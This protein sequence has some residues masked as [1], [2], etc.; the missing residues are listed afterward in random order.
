MAGGL[1]AEGLGAT[2]LAVVAALEVDGKT[3]RDE[4]AGLVLPP[5][6]WLLLDDLGVD[7]ATVWLLGVEV[8]DVELETVEGTTGTT[9]EDKDTTLSGP[10]RERRRVGVTD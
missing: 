7:P 3:V 4:W 6:P 10:F 1:A 5:W 2:G 9:V 8:E